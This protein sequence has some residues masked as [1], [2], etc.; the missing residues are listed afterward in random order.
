V[1]PAKLTHTVHLPWG[2][3]CH[4]TLYRIS[5]CSTGGMEYLTYERYI[6]WKTELERELSKTS[7]LYLATEA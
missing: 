7:C 3:G 1:C 6:L 2:E 5:L 4:P